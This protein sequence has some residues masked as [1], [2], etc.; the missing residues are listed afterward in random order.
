MFDG[1]SEGCIA[2]SA[3]LLI[4]TTTINVVINIVI[5]VVILVLSSVSSSRRCVLC[6]CCRCIRRRSLGRQ[7]H[8]RRDHAPAHLHARRPA[9]I[10]APATGPVRTSKYLPLCDVRVRDCFCGGH[11]LLGVEH[12]GARDEVDGQGRGVGQEGAPRAA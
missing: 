10:P 2:T 12:D 9:L 7:C 8:Q 6:C 5:A 11:A 1:D 4:T 3:L